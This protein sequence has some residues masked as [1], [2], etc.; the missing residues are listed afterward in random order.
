M[1][2]DSKVILGRVYVPESNQ[3]YWA[4]D[5]CIEIEGPTIFYILDHG[6]WSPYP[7]LTQEAILLDARYKRFKHNQGV[8]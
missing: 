4:M 7:V 6:N 8:V 3:E 2:K 1:H 5:V